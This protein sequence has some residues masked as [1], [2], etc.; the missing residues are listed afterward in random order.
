MVETARPDA[1]R[2]RRHI[3]RNCLDVRAG[4][5]S[6][7][8]PWHRQLN[9]GPNGRATEILTTDESINPFSLCAATSEPV[10][11]LRRFFGTSWSALSLLQRRRGNP[12][13]LSA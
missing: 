10:R 13:A 8:R 12:P 7:A 11:R 5:L 6:A 1:D 3:A 4:H 9:G 2:A